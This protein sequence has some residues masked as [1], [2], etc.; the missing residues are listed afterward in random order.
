VADRIRKVQEFIGLPFA[1]ENPSYYMRMP[2]STMS[3]ADFITRIVES[4]DC[5]LLLD[6]NNVY[7]NGT[8]HGYDPW[9]FMESLPL[10]RVLQLHMAGHHILDDGMLFD[11]HGKPVPAPVWSLFEQLI[12]QEGSIPTL[13]EWDNDIPAWDRLLQEANTAE[14]ILSKA[15]SARTERPSQ[16]SGASTEESVQIYAGP[17]HLDLGDFFD[18][19]APALDGRTP[20][21]QVAE[22]LFLNELGTKR[23]SFYSNQINQHAT[24]ILEMVYPDTRRALGVACFQD[25]AEQYSE[26]HPMNHY[27]WNQ[28][29]CFFPEFLTRAQDAKSG[30]RP[31]NWAHALASLEWDWFATHTNP[32]PT[33]VSSPGIHINPTLLWLSFAYKVASWSLEEAD[34]RP[35]APEIGEESVIMFRHPKKLSTR[36][37]FPGQRDLLAMKMVAEDLRRETVQEMTGAS[38]QLLE[39][40]LNEGVR[41]GYLVRGDAAQVALDQ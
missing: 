37:I 25:L 7:V 4:A 11:T 24:S 21:D 8:N 33:T 12:R 30:A 22:Q 39:D 40:V 10:D 3:E 9:T 18:R 41:A 26:A 14:R 29:A 27:E 28:T 32:A 1:L 35:D 6:V 17:Q 19:V 16:T 2:G 20:V 36:V 13:I 5:G 15:L 38:P 34:S 23:L 31:P